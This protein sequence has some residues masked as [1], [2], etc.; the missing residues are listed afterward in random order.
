MIVVE[1]ECER[2]DKRGD[3]KGM[4]REWSSV[5]EER[6]VKMKEGREVR[7]LESSHEE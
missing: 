4:E 3:D 5:R 6:P 2:G 1:R 7:L